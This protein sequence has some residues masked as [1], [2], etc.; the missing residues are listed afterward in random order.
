MRSMETTHPCLDGVISPR[1]HVV[2]RRTRSADRVPIVSDSRLEMKTVIQRHEDP[3]DYPTPPSIPSSA[4]PCC[5]PPPHYG[6]FCGLCCQVKP[7]RVRDKWSGR[8]ER[9]AW[10][11][12]LQGLKCVGIEIAVTCTSDLGQQKRAKGCRRYQG[13]AGFVPSSLPSRLPSKVDASFAFVI[14]AVRRLL[15]LPGPRNDIRTARPWSW[16]ALFHRCRS[17]PEGSCSPPIRSAPC[18]T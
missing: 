8:P 16:P 4:K 2:R 14:R 17:H 10:N 13:M 1:K 18:L 7:K 11:P 12:D 3:S 15:K 5:D 9:E 6:Q